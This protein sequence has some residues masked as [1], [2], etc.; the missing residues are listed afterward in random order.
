[1]AYRG[2]VPGRFPT[3]DLKRSRILEISPDITMIEG[4]ISDDFFFKPPSC[5]CFVLRDG[6]MVLLVDTGTYPFYRRAILDV[7]DRHR[8][9]GAK[10]LVLM[11]TQGHFDHVANNDVIL[12]AGYGDVRFLLPEVELPVIDLFH[13]WMGDFEAMTEY[14]NPYREFPMVFPTAVIGLTGRMSARLARS[15]LSSSCRMLFR[16]IQNLADRAEILRLDERVEWGF[17]DVVFKGWEVGRFLAVHDATHSPGHLSFYDPQDKVFLTGD[18]TL[19][20]NPA[21]FDSSLETCIEMMGRFRRFAELGYVETATDAHRSSIWAQELATAFDY[22]PIH[23]LQA[24]DAAHGGDE[25]A[26]LYGFFEEYYAALKREVMSAL[27]RLREA[28]VPEMVEEFEGSRDPNARFKTTLAFPRVPSR[29]DVM[30]ANV[31]KENGIQRRREGE[32]IV[33]SA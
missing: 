28:T 14:Y 12:E 33:F 4:Y 15:L 13:H 17:G 5:N 25:C 26:A 31:M 16:G 30:V 10:R 2:F 8:R 6:D 11:L 23:P 7:L 18:A 27:T 9:D 1:M 32:R 20:I 19:E 24:V 3:A 29:V 21:F 22:N